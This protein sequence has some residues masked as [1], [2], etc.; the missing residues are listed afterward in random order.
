VLAAFYFSRSITSPIT[1]LREGAEKVSTGQHNVE[2]VVDSPDEIA[3][4]ADSF[5]RMVVARNQVEEE[6]RLHRDHL[7]ELVEERTRELED[8]QEALLRQER[9]A[10]LG[11]LA[12]GLGHE[13]RN[14]LGVVKNACYFLNMKRRFIEDEAVQEHLHIIDQQVA[15]ADGVITNMLDFAHVKAPTRQ[16][17][18]VA[19]L[20]TEA[21]SACPRPENC[22]VKADVAEG[23]SPIFADP[24]QVHQ[25]FVNLIQNAYQ[26]MGEGGTLTISARESGE[27]LDVV[28]VDEG[29]GIPQAQLDRIFEPLFTT[30][31]RGMGLGLSICQ[32]LA[33]ANGATISVE[34]EEGTGSRF[35]V[36]FDKR[37]RIR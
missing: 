15:N 27:M 7:E 12:A 20:V 11:Q 36:R 13:L 16:E 35:T 1:R 22:V 26:S 17:T 5:N 31:A 25:I 30:K 32:N 3:N 33:E 24:L 28:F 37:G 29:S 19:Q 2:I 14:T 8:I 6:L 21:I 34:S 10:A 4:L 9:L 23:L 18:Y